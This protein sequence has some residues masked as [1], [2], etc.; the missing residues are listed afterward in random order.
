MSLADFRRSSQHISI[1]FLILMMASCDILAD[2]G[3]LCG[4]VVLVIVLAWIAAV[5]F[6]IEELGNATGHKPPL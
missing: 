4:A 2:L 6:S 5:S 1:Y 3:D